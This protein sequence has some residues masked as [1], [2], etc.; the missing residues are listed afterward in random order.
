V[1]ERD[2]KNDGDG[3]CPPGAAARRRPAERLPEPAGRAHA[4]EWNGAEE[5]PGEER[6]GADEE[7][8]ENCRESQR[9]Y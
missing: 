5:E 4:E 1:R 8:K 7:R 3:E 9:R 6:L 2:R